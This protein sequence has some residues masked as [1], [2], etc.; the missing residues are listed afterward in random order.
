MATR[1]ENA[2]GANRGANSKQLLQND[3]NAPISIGCAEVKAAILL[4]DIGASIGPIECQLNCLAAMVAAGDST[5]IG[6]DQ[7][8]PVKIEAVPMRL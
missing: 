5:G 2:A 7:I 3:D 1:H 8:P 6:G 4:D